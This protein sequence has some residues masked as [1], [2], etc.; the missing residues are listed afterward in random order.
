MSEIH[1]E[2]LQLENGP[3]AWYARPGIDGP[4]PGVVIFIE[5]FGINSHFQEVAERFAKAGYC[6]I[7]PDLYHGKTY[8]YAD[9][10]N[11]IGHLKTLKDDLAMQEAGLAIAELQ[12]RPEVMK[13]AIGAVG[14][15][16]GGRFA[17]MANAVHADKLSASVAFYGGGIAPDKD[18][19]GR[20]PLLHLVDQMRAPLL[21]LYGAED[22]SITPEE[23]GRIAAALSTAKKRYTLT[24]FPGAPHGFFAD[25]RDSYRPEAAAEGWRLTL[26]HFSQHL[27]GQA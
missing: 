13:H 8:E 6:A 25:P 18:P 14:F 23:H 17:F 21:L 12:K 11:A 15:C 19:A 20:Q 4:Y 3:R 27:G 7:V 9:F 22:H 26:D 1:S 2:W 10:E 5:A 24:L 16:M